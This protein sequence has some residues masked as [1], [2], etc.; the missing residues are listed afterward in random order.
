MAYH[1][2]LTENPAD[3]REHILRMWQEYLP[4]TPPRRYEW[5][6]EGNPAGKAKW[7]LA[8]DEETGDLIGFITLLPRRFIYKGK[9]MLFG[10]MGDYV[11]E[12]MRR[13]FGPG[14]QLPKHVLERAKDLGFSLVYTIPYYNSLKPVVRAGFKL[15][16][17]LGWL[18]KPL[19]FNSYLDNPAAIKLLNLCA[20]VF[21]RLCS[22][23]FLNPI[24]LR[25]CYFEADAA[26]DSGFDELWAKLKTAEKGVIGSRD[27]RY[28]AWRY[29]ENPLME[30]RMLAFRQKRPEAL[31]GYI[32]YTT[33]GGKLNIYDI[34]YH[35]RRYRILLIQKLVQIARE[36][37]CEAVYLLSSAGNKDLTALRAFG[38]VP[39]KE[40]HALYY[41]ALGSG[42]DL[43][44]WSFFQGDRNV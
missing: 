3:Y 20:S 9:D 2:E 34:Q 22:A 21:D 32:I 13:G 26:I 38:F 15:K 31:L 17:Q 27:P 24:V 30:F 11:V 7:F 25:G 39:R 1:I 44:T 23:L 43:D 18:I 40:D 6:T 12:K 5:L 8:I 10:I 19:L 36:E 14:M 33:S 37:G 4:D 28:L 29:M 35:Q 42:A 41:A 16:I